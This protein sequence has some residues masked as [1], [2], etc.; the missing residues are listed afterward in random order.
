MALLVAVPIGETL[1]LAPRVSEEVAVA[2]AD[3]VA[4]GGGGEQQA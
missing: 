1:A 3:A 4:D 2:V